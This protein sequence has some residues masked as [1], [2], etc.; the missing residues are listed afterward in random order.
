MEHFFPQELLQRSVRV[1]LVGAG[2]N[3]SRMLTGLAELDYAIR[4]CGHPGG[5]DVT[6]Y[7]DDLVSESNVGRQRFSPADVG[8]NKAVVLVHRLNMSY[9]LAWKA[10]PQRFAADDVHGEDL[11][12]VVSCVDTKGARREIHSGIIDSY[13]GLYWLDLG[14]RASDGQVVLGQGQGYMQKTEPRLPLVTELFSEILDESIPE[15]ETTPSCSVAEALERQE[16]FIN[17]A[18]C[19]FALDLLYKLFRKGKISHHGAFV[20]L[21][22]GR[23]T[24]LAVDPEGWKRLG[25]KEL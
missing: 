10:V 4:K 14:N 6:V 21:E 24:P 7:D 16:L 5:L 8:I 9:G 2:G 12:L 15:D 20:N 22:A 3:G 11:D 1:S 25:F 13:R 17:M 18:V 19:A 23:V